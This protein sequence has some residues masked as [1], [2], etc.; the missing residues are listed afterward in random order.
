MQAFEYGLMDAV[1]ANMWWY[2][3]LH[4]RLSDALDVV[5][6]PAMPG[7]GKPDASTPKGIVTG[8][9]ATGVSTIEA[10]VPRPRLA[11]RLLDAGCGTGGFL[12]VMKTCRPDLLGIGVEWNPM[13]ARCAKLKSGTAVLRGSVN[14]LPFTD[15]CFDVA[16]SADVLCHVAVNPAAALRELKRVLRPGGRL[17]VNV[18]AYQWLHSAHDRRV[19][20]VRRMTASGTARMLHYAGFIRVRAHYWNALLLPLMV[21]QRK[22]LARGDAASDVAAFPPWLNTVLHAMTEVERCLPFRLPV[23]GSVLAIAEKL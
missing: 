9:G 1:E 2:R 15:A 7:S 16:V 22:I 4:A 13:A 20:N 17:I 8:A 5:V 23:G 18:P 19:H 21:V 10:G 11:A 14:A 6:G 12:A 3:A